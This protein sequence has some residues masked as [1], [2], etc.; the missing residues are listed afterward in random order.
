M[1]LYPEQEREVNGHKKQSDR[2]EA[3]HT[4]RQYSIVRIRIV[5]EANAQPTDGRGRE[6]HYRQ[7]PSLQSILIEYQSREHGRHCGKNNKAGKPEAP[8]TILESLAGRLGEPVIDF[9]SKR[10]HAES[11]SDKAQELTTAGA[12]ARIAR[13]RQA[14]VRLF[15]VR[16][17][18]VFSIR[19]PTINLPSFI[20][21]SLLQF[22]ITDLLFYTPTRIFL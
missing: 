8:F 6:Q 13:C 16:S 5:Q 22:A 12:L 19:G 9:V 17:A 3:G 1:P 4:Y 15:D 20:Y 7:K 10:F 2:V 14:P 21:T 11:L 18:S